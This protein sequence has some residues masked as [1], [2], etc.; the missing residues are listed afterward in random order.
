M[1]DEDLVRKKLAAIETYVRELRDLADLDR[2]QHD[3]K[4]E[5]F[6]EHTLQIAVQAVQDVA[7]HVVSDERLGEPRTNRELFTLLARNGWI[8]ASL[9]D[10]LQRAVGFRNLLVHG[11]AAVEPELVREVASNH[12]E[13]LL[14]FVRAIRERL[15]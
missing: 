1:T 9:A 10:A 8:E 12:V 2:I 6:F 15:G 13:D 4:E 7:S 14:R 5:R 11:Y 3:L